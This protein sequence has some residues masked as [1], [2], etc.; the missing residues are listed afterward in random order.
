[1]IERG[2]TL[3]L[4]EIEGLKTAAKSET[5]QAIVSILNAGHRKGAFVPRC[6]GGGNNEVQEFHTYG[7][8][9]FCA[10]GKLPDTLMDRSIIIGMQRRM[11]A[12]SVS[13]FLISRATPEGTAVHAGIV[14]YVRAY[15]SVI[16]E[17][18]RHTIDQDLDYLEDRDADLWMSVIAVCS[19]TDPGRLDELKR[20]AI[21][22]SQGKAGDEADDPFA[23]KLLRDMREVWPVKTNQPEPICPTATLLERLKGMSDS[24]WAGPKYVL[25]GR[26]MADL[27]RPFEVEPKDLRTDEG[28]LRGYEYGPLATA[29]ER[30]LGQKS[31]TS[32]TNQ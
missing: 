5:A 26:R 30:Y 9:V 27:L 6:V 32:T 2:P 20:C 18:Y 19:A 4:D 7:P 3:L 14:C 21:A 24:R 1:M 23:V 29:F 8:K 12:Q 17:A 11:K 10:I 16:A 13:R 31:A 22:L 25:N 28:T 15:A